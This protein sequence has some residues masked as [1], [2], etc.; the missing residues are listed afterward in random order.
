MSF[1]VTGIDHVVLNCTDVEVT[2]RWY[3]RAL[4]VRV[5]TYG[6]GRTALTFGAQKLNLR[7]V[8][9]DG[10]ETARADVPGSLDIC[11]VTTAT[12]EE[13]V[14]AWRTAGIDVHEGP[15]RRTGARG[16][17]TSVYA[18]DPDGNLVEVA[19]YDSP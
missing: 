5:E 4:G 2:A 15:I 8:G 1:D 14:S 11:F 3:R 16:A 17:I 12:I 19:R 18:R 10:W 13:V 7:P 9:T 6:A